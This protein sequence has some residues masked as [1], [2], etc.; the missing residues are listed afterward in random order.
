M[1]CENCQD[2]FQVWNRR[3]VWRKK[4]PSAFCKTVISR[5]TAHM[6]PSHQFSQKC[7]LRKSHHTKSKLTSSQPEDQAKNITSQHSVG[8]CEVCVHHQH[9]LWEENDVHQVGAQEP[10][11]INGIHNNGHHSGSSRDEQNGD[12]HH[13]D[14]FPF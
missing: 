5:L 6:I 7:F 12:S 13:Q 11:A 3:R 14:H 4:Q 1:P 8:V 10:Q 2:N 9:Q